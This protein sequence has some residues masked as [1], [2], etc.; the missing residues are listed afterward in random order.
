MVSMVAAVVSAIASY[1]LVSTLFKLVPFETSLQRA[2]ED[3]NKGLPRMVDNSTRFAAATA[4]PGLKFSYVYTLLHASEKHPDGAAFK[5]GMRTKLIATYRGNPKM[6]NYR[7]HNVEL[8]YRY[9]DEAGAPFC[10][11]AISPKDF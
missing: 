1:L 5:Q 9:R 4:G 3:L 7:E 8:V 6:K 11:I 10:E 2:A